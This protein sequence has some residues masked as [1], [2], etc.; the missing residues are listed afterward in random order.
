MKRREFIRLMAFAPLG[1][2]AGGRAIYS[3]A[4]E[5]KGGKSL[6]GIRNN[7]K[8]LLPKGAKVA[9]STEPLRRSNEEWKRIVSAQSRITS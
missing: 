5:A 8:A 7:W 9:L 4:A 2:A 3:M 1:M 6:E